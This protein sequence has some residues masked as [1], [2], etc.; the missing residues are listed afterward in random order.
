M[1]RL[2]LLLALLTGPLNAQ[3]PQPTPSPGGVATTQPYFRATLPGGTYTVATRAI[4]AVSSHEYLAD[5]IARVTEV[6]I[7][8]TGALVA[9]FYFLEPAS[10]SAPGNIG[11]A[12]LEKAQ[13]L[14]TEA[15]DRTGQDV[16]KKVVK[17]Y[18]TTTHARTVE[19]RVS[20]KDQLNKLFAAADEAFRLGR[21][22]TIK[23][24]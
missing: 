24:E 2:L 4:V 23:V 6:N 1:R 10:I 21:T 8:T 20:S 13:A 14:L 9:R 3:T 17:N 12:T 18:P 19:Y 5:G 22:T 16:W 15:A 11:A 7:D